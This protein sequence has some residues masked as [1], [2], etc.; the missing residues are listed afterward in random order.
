MNIQILPGLKSIQHKY[1][2]FLVDVWGVL[3]DGQDLYPYALDCLEQLRENQKKVVIISN[4][5]RRHDTIIEELVNLGIDRSLYH[6][7]ASS[8]ELVWQSIQRQEIQTV[9][10]KGYYLG[11]L[12]SRSLLDGLVVNWVEQLEDADF[13]LNA[14]AIEGNSKDTSGY[15][16]LLNTAS[17]LDLPMIC[18]NPDMVAVRVGELG[19]S[20]GAIAERYRQLGANQIEFYGKPFALIYQLALAL[21]DNPYHE[22]VLAIGDA[23]ATDIVGAGNMGLD[24]YLIAAGI[25]HQDLNPLSLAALELTA[26]GLPLPNYA[27]EYFQ[28]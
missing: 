12:R 5:A 22:K 2:A 7:V 14:G 19:I 3:H 8:G 6:G 28:W 9:R 24:S 1:Q 27:S 18:A 23:Y 16:V 13:I 11:P 21:L 17:Q 10:Q 15:D 25:H 26:A 4:A 20:A